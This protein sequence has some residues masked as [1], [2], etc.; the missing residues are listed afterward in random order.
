MAKALQDG[1]EAKRRRIKSAPS[2]FE[3]N[4]DGEVCKGMIG[5]LGGDRYQAPRSRSANF[6]ARTSQPAKDSHV[7]EAIGRL[8]NNR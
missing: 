4:E 7:Q 2:E 8:L 5:E 3:K 6:G 1:T